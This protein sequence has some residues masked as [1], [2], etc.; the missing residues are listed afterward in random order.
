MSSFNFSKGGDTMT[1]ITTRKNRAY[2]FTAKKDAKPIPQMPRDKYEA[3]VARGK[4][5]QWKK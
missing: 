2:I 4:E 3:A 1:V 5:L